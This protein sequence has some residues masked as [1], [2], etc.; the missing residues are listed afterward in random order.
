MKVIYISI[1]IVL[2]VV[3][4]SVKK[5]N[6]YNLE[7]QTKADHDIKYRPSVFNGNIVPAKKNTSVT[8]TDLEN[9][10]KTISTYTN[11]PPSGANT[12][13]N[14]SKYDLLFKDVLKLK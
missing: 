14:Q 2:L 13:T 5:D 12:S 6:F 10:F 1:I 7:Q 8:K 4:F 11:G 9:L 3:F